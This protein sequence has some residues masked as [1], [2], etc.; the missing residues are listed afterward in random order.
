V[1]L[2]VERGDIDLN[3]FSSLWNYPIIE[4]RFTPRLSVT[5]FRKAL[6]LRLRLIGA[7]GLLSFREFRRVWDRQ[8]EN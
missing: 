5:I 8:L 7:P 1:V 4:N 6:G 2:Q 3:I